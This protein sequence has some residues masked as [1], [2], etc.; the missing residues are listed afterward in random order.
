M[1]S[2]PTREGQPRDE[3]AVEAANFA[4]QI[5]F[6]WKAMNAEDGVAARR[7]SDKMLDKSIGYAIEILKLL[8]PERYDKPPAP[9]AVLSLIKHSSARRIWR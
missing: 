8:D 7:L 6:E 2:A 3:T 1:L 4:I 9:A 5:Y